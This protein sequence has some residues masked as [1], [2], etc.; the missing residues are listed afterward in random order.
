MA[1][2]LFQKNKCL[3]VRFEGVR[4]GFLSKR[5]DK[6]SPFR[7]AEHKKGAGTSNEKSGTGNME[8]ESLGSGAD[9]M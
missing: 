5:K 7:E 9:S 6:V 8:A 3:E 2:L 1:G 4:Q